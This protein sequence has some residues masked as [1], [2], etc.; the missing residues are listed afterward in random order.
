M[1]TTL[2][3]GEAARLQDRPVNPLPGG[4]ARA[5]QAPAAPGRP[6]RRRHSSSPTSSCKCASTATWR[7]SRASMKELLAEEKRTAGRGARPRSSSTRRPHGFDEFAARARR[8]ELGRASSS[9][10]ASR[11]KQMREAAQVYVERR[12]H[13]RLLGD[14]AHAAQERG[15]QHPGDRQPAAAARAD[16]PA[17]A[18]ACARCAATA[19][20]RATA[21]WA[22][23]SGRP[24]PSSTRSAREFD[25]E[26]PRRHGLDTV[27][28]IQAMHDGKVKSSSRSAATS[29]RPRP[30]PSSPPTR[31]AAAA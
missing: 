14:G 17:A 6:A 3:R 18:R 19:T 4:R 10:A 28:T 26:P 29:S 1:L 21:R 9:R 31:C 8:D 23:G 12:A 22:S 11:A 27:E 5:L 13:H 7:S 25:F 30:T 2:Q 16:R 15:R 24:T 20:C